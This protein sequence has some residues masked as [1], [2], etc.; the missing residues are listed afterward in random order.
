[1]ETY[2]NVCGYICVRFVDGLCCVLVHEC[3]CGCMLKEIGEESK[4]HYSIQQETGISA[5]RGVAVSQYSMKTWENE[6]NS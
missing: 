5:Y 3:V 1:M 4:M 6:N 2:I